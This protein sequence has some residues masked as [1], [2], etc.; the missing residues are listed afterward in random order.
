M[1]AANLLLL[2]LAPAE[3][4]PTSGIRDFNGKE[5]NG[6]TL[7]VTTD[8]GIKKMYRTSRGASR[9][10]GLVL[11]TDRGAP[12]VEAMLRG[13]G[14]DAKLIGFYVVFNQ[15]NRGP[16]D[17][18]QSTDDPGYPRTRYGEVY[19]SSDVERGVVA[20]ISES[21]RSPRVLAALLTDPQFARAVIEEFPARQSPVRNERELRDNIPPARFSRVSF[22]LSDR[23]DLPERRRLEDILDRRFRD[24]L[25]S[26]YLAR[27]DSG[28]A[29]ATANTSWSD[30]D[31]GRVSVNVTIEASNDYG[32]YRST[33]SYSTTF[34]KRDG[35]REWAFR[36][37]LFLGTERA[38][39]DAV[40][41]IDDQ[42]RRSAPRDADEFAKFDF[43]RTLSPIVK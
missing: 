24:A 22:S 29:S 18:V 28:Y 39:R 25:E 21:Q 30:N 37:S 35:F 20:L 19:V 1:L 14:R 6:L 17:F 41:S 31:G 23:A 2:A 26:N 11:D 7:G 32:T 36:D 33:G 27:G 34:D 16:E 38:T 13:R 8:D 9:P 3:L 10:E 4:F 40:R 43:W 5:W 12:R 42:V 15:V